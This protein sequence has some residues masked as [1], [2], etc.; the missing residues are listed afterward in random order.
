MFFFKISFFFR[1]T[2]GRLFPMVFTT[3][4]L[5][6]CYQSLHHD[7][8]RGMNDKIHM[9][10]LLLV[11]KEQVKLNFQAVKEFHANSKQVIYEAYK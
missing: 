11:P 4:P 10:Y 5:R 9:P 7:M 1:I 3:F 6:G 2:T 8:I